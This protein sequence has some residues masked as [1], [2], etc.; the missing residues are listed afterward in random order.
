MYFVVIEAVVAAVV[1][2]YAVARGLQLLF[3]IEQGVSKREFLS[4]LRSFASEKVG[5]R[6]VSLLC[7]DSGDEE[8]LCSLLSVEYPDYEVVVTADSLRNAESL[9]RIVS[10]YRMVA[11]ER[12]ELSEEWSSVRRLYRSAS[13]CYRRLI[14]LD[15]ST[16]GRAEDF[17]AACEVATYDLLLPLWN[18]EVLLPG[19]I[20]RLVAEVVLDRKKSK[21]PV[22]TLLGAAIT[23]Y[24]R[25]ALC[26]KIG[27]GGADRNCRVRCTLLYEPLAIGGSSW[28][29]KRWLL[30]TFVGAVVV[31]CVVALIFRF[32]AIFAVALLLAVGALFILSFIAYKLVMHEEKGAVGYGEILYR[33]FENL[34]PW[35]WKIRK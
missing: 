18:D 34:L 12:S 10:R 29:G 3:R 24:P 27:S 25:A 22:T 15:V 5:R 33:F 1:A 19:A 28:R 35:I 30:F 7:R 16:V 6:G 21:R 2:L 13:R 8:R 9:Q 11:V 32:L 14:L 23:L 20:E 4:S 26:E 31:A 17:D